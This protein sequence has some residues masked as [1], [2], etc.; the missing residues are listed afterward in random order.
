MSYALCLPKIIF[1]KKIIKYNN[2]FTIYKSMRIKSCPICNRII[3]ESEKGTS[4]FNKI[5]FCSYKCAYGN[6]T[7]D[8]ELRSRNIIKKCLICNKE[9]KVPLSRKTT[10]KFCSHQCRGKSLIKI[11]KDRWKNEEFRKRIMKKK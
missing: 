6:R 5:R 10:T 7:R 11:L 2:N 8:I 4:N 9:M 3:K 1:K